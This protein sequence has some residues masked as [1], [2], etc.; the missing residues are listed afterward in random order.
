MCQRNAASFMAQRI[1]YCQTNPSLKFGWA[2]MASVVHPMVQ[3]LTRSSSRFGMSASS[4]SN[5][6]ICI[7][8]AC[9][10]SGSSFRF[11]ISLKDARYDL[12]K[13]D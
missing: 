11:V 9:R 5:V 12:Q 13:T 3:P 8:S 7:H 4:V 1:P 6:C 2:V 10:T